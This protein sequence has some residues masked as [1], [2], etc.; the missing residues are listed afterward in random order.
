[1]YSPFPTN[2]PRIQIWRRVSAMGPCLKASGARSGEVF[3]RNIR[4][5]WTINALAI[6]YTP[7]LILFLKPCFSDGKGDQVV[8]TTTITPSDSSFLPLNIHEVLE[9]M[10]VTDDGLL[11]VGSLPLFSQFFEEL[12]GK[13][14]KTR[15]Q[16]TD[17]YFSNC[18]KRLL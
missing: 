8:A 13:F 17:F 9:V 15:A 18:F 1:M 2:I 16:R 6:P 4:W 10:S 14:I 7:T 5:K 11:M 3:P 12:L